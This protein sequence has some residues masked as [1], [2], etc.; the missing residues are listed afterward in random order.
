MHDFEIKGSSSGVEPVQKEN[1]IFGNE[2][3]K[4]RVSRD[5][6]FCYFSG[7]QC[8]ECCNIGVLTLRIFIK[9]RDYLLYTAACG[10]AVD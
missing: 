5:Y 8:V 4:N 3:V 9:V 7:E 10:E 1:F 6:C 2:L